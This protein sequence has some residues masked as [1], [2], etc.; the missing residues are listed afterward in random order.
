[1]ANWRKSATDSSKFDIVPFRSGRCGK[2]RRLSNSK[3]GAAGGPLIK[4][5]DASSAVVDGVVDVVIKGH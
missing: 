1:M 5:R 4:V 2:A 3:P